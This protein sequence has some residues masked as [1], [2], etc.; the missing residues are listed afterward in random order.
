VAK[1]EHQVERTLDCDTSLAANVQ[2]ASRPEA[3]FASLSEQN[4]RFLA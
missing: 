3:P 4:E 1:N 2:Y